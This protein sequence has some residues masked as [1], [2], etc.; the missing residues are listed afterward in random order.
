MLLSVVF[1]FRNEEK[2]LDELIRRVK[3]S[4]KKTGL[5][6]EIIFVNDDSTDKSA[7]IIQKHQTID[8]SIKLINMSKRF[9]V[10]PCVIAGLRHAKGD[11]IV[12]MDTDLQDPP[13]VIPQ[14]VEKW[15]AG[16]DVV[17]TVRTKRLGENPFKM[18][19]TKKAYQVINFVSDINLPPNMG[20]FKLLSRR[21]VDELLQIQETDPFMR[22]LVRWIG[23]KQETVYYV[24]EA[25]Y[26]G[27]THFSLFGS[28]PVK[29]FIRGIASFSAA[30]LYA[31]VIVGILVSFC[32]FAFIIYVLIVWLMGL[33]V[34]GWAG[35]MI[36][37][38]LLGGMILFSNGLNGIYIG[39]IYEQV[40]NRPLY[41]I[42]NKIG[43][44]EP[45]NKS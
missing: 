26:A 30:P 13:E 36:A 34:P 16:A 24:R 41:I 1:S 19:L 2:V 37:V 6:S 12:Y 40:K 11:A 10:H 31:S 42:K 29:E 14:L 8:S 28:G 20:D 38:L 43:F 15:K 21:V 7:D 45:Q 3:E 18:W 32:S 33:A 23:F 17:N 25:R 9:G 39:R 27:K 4:A 22:G 5:D 44:D 35:V